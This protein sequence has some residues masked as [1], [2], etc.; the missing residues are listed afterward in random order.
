MAK[1]RTTNSIPDKICITPLSIS[2][3]NEFHEHSTFSCIIFS[4]H[5]K[6]KNIATLQ[7]RE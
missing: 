6:K 2:I 1:T 4:L 7:L 3:Y 5:K